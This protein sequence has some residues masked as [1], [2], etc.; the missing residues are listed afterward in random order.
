MRNFAL[1]DSDSQF[2]FVSAADAGPQ[3]VNIGPSDIGFL[4]T[5][6]CGT[7]TKVGV[8]E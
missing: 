1:S 6:E 3:V 4:T 5:E 2:G 7:W 8:S